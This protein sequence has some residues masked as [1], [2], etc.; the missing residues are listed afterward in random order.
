MKSIYK[1]RYTALTDE[2][3]VVFLVGMR[4]NRWWAV[5]QWW[6]VYQA[7]KNML[8]DLQTPPDQGMNSAHT[9]ISWREIMVTT[10]WH[11]YEQLENYARSA[12]SHTS[13]WA[14]FNKKIGASGA[15]GIWHE[16]FVVEANKYECVYVNMPQSGLAR[17]KNTR[18]VKAEGAHETSRLRMG[19]KNR[20]AVPSPTTPDAKESSK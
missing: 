14:A 4:I 19:G 11:S 8:I 7:M 12:D 16:T 9:R 13:P 17:G 18:F 1:G 10:Y 3:M 2:S 6:P 20:P 15:V 5:H